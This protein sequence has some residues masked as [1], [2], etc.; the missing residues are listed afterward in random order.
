[1]KKI[2]LL[3]LPFVFAYSQKMHGQVSFFDANVRNGTR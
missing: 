3:L 1:M 2:I